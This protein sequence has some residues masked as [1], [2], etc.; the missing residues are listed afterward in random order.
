M[1]AVAWI[2]V[3][4]LLPLSALDAFMVLGGFFSMSNADTAIAQNWIWFYAGPFSFLPALVLGVLTAS[5]FRA[6][7]FI[8]R[9]Y[10]SP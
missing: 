9:G 8:Y 6:A 2:V 10:L 4:L 3:I 1:R 5:I 7:R